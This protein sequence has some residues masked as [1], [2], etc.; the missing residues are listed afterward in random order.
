MRWLS[1]IGLVVFSSRLW[2][3]DESFTAAAA[4]DGADERA[5]DDVEPELVSRRYTSRIHR[6]TKRTN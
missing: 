2:A 3:G 1:L 6:K 4:S 5:G